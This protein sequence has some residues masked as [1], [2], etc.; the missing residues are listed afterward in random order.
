MLFKVEPN[1]DIFI[2][3][4]ELKSNNVFAACS[5]RDLKYIFLVYDYK[6]VLRQL[7]LEH[8]K[9]KAIIDAG[10]NMEK[11]HKRPD[12]R[13][14]D[15]LGGKKRNVNAAIAEFKV[16]QYDDDRALVNS[17]KEQIQQYQEFFNRK[18]KSAVELEKAIKFI[19]ALPS[20]KERQKELEIVLKLRDEDEA[21]TQREL[22]TIDEIND[23]N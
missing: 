9:Q 4:P 2:S 23:G 7:P 21:K 3:N 22:S 18:D 19:D 6:S 8:R 13:A 10:F 15:V 1:I 20:I 12:R 5:S 14:R 17:V 16:I 11:D